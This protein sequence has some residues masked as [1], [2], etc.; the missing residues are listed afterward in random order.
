VL[1]CSQEVGKRLLLVSGHAKAE[2]Y[3]IS[4]YR[5]WLAWVR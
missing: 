3:V 2:K 4:P 5:Q 1:G